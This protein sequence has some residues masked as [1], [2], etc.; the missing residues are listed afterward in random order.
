MKKI[1]ILVFIVIIL[2]IAF[3]F[4]I[5][6]SNLENNANNTNTYKF[7]K[8]DILDLIKNESTQHSYTCKYYE[9][10]S[11]RVSKYKDDV[12]ISHNTF[13][14][15]KFEITYDNYKTNES[16]IISSKSNNAMIEDCY[17]S[18]EPLLYASY[19][20]SILI[21]TDTTYEYLRNDIYNE[22]DCIVT[23]WSTNNKNYELWFDFATGFLVK[24]IKTDDSE[25]KIVEYTVTLDDV[26][27]EDIQRPDITNYNIIDV[28]E[29]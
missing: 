8:E 3:C 19:I 17:S 28:R 11:S 20:Y 16:I 15:N 1:L 29:K 18:P 24:Q 22:R 21:D 27:Y 14:D 2:A 12:F 4:K 9:F 7:S 10:G 25:T 23:L 6:S 26:K 13:D 5:F